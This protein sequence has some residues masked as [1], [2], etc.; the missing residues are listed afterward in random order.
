MTV[1][2]AIDLMEG[3]CVRLTEGIFSTSRVYSDDPVETAKTFADMGAKRLHVVDLDAALSRSDNRKTIKAIRGA[4]PGLIEVGGGVRQSEAAAALID[5][6]IDKIVVGTA[7]VKKPQE[8]GEWA[9]RHGGVFIAGIDARDGEV[10]TSGWEEGSTLSA[11]ELALQAKELGIT[12]IIFTDISRDGTLRGP[13]TQS[14]AAIA[15]A[16]GL[17][18]ILSGGV[19]RLSHL[20][21]LANH[22]PKG[23]SGLIIGKA[24]YEGSIDL[25][26]AMA[27]LGDSYD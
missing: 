25:Q 17:P 12:E 23:I 15:K 22:T 1:I 14:A 5:M 6:G 18:V 11:A 4:F 10:R 7:L 27:L 16:S 13:N 9:A 24:L 21:A 26:E 19:G 8:V 2:P 3:R 20:E